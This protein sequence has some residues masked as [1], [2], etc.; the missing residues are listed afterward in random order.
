VRYEAGTFF[1]PII[2]E[3]FE[4]AVTTQEMDYLTKYAVK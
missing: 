4:K 1:D 2:A 3:A